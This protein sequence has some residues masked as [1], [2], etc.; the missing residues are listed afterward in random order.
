MTRKKRQGFISLPKLVAV[1]TF[2][3]VAVLMI[4]F[5]R[6][7][8]DNYQIQRQVEWLREQAAIERDAHDSL[9]EELEYASS[10]AYVEKI[11]RERLKLVQPGESAVVVVPQ[12]A[13][14]PSASSDS[15]ATGIQEDE[16]L[17]YWQQWANLLLGSG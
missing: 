4:D 16:A 1:V 12:E 5:G 3:L 11:A 6:K 7:A 14:A 9:Q 15:P 17:P 8:L 10:D 13:E 2:T